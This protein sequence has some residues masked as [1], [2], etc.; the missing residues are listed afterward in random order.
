M[1]LIKSNATQ[2][3]EYATCFTMLP[4]E[5]ECGDQYVV[6]PTKNG[7]LIAVVDG[8]GHGSEAAE[9]ARV[10]SE[11]IKRQADDESVI[12]LIRHCNEEMKRTRGAV[13][14]LAAFNA[15]DHTV[16]L[17]SVGNVEGVLLRANAHADPN[18]ENVMMRG[19][20]VGSHLP[21]LQALVVPVFPGDILI[22]ATDG[23]R[24]GFD[25]NV[26]L[27]ASVQHIADTICRQ[28]NKGNDDA[29]VLV[30]RFLG[31]GP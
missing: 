16:T 14:S 18:R 1:S 31:G 27:G 17:L 11:I 3:I 5:Q 29:L 2:L 7:T 4:G 9:S 28:Y 25:Q 8:L 20:V 6:Q 12:S 30:S 13:I 10:A 19:G 21:T 22:F 26:P 24:N 23:I 15:K